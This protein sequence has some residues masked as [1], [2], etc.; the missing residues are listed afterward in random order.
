MTETLLYEPHALVRVVRLAV[1]LACLEL[2][3][4][5]Q[6][7]WA[8]LRARGS[9]HSVVRKLALGRGIPTRT[10]SPMRNWQLRAR[11]RRRRRPT[12]LNRR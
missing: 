2:A 8:E 9:A 5:A 1:A 7:T 12:K 4:V 11:R 3:R 10:E 6:A